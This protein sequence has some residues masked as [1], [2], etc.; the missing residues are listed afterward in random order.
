MVLGQAPT[1]SPVRHS[2]PAGRALDPDGSRDDIW[3]WNGPVEIVDLP[4][5]MVIF[6]R[7][8]LMFT[9]KNGNVFHSYVSLP[10][11]I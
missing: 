5:S 7:F 10:E 1:W 9:I 2:T 8:L 11:G 3:T 6:H 4:S